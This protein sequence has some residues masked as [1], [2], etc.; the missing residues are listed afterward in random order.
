MSAS[1]FLNQP[2][3][4]VY[5]LSGQTEATVRTDNGLGK[6][7]V[8]DYPV[9]QCDMAFARYLKGERLPTDSSDEA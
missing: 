4:W 5:R 6:K 3:A 7:E 1:L 2:M 8:K 9:C